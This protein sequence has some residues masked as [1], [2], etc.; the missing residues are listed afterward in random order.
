LE[1]KK[2]GHQQAESKAEQD[3]EQTPSIEELL[4]DLPLSL[5]QSLQSYRHK[6]VYPGTHKMEAEAETR[7]FEDVSQLTPL[8]S[9]SIASSLMETAASTTTSQ[10]DGFPSQIPPPPI[11]S[12]Q[13]EVE[14]LSTSYLP[15]ETEEDTQSA[16]QLHNSLLS[17][18]YPSSSSPS[19]SSHPSRSHSSHPSHSLSSLSNKHRTNQLYNELQDDI[20]LPPVYSEVP[21]LDSIPAAPQLPRIQRHSLSNAAATSSTQD[22][23]LNLYSQSMPSSNLYSQPYPPL[24]QQLLQ[25][26]ER[27]LLQKHHRP[28]PPLSSQQHHAAQQHHS[29]LLQQTQHTQ[30]HQ[31]RTEP[32]QQHQ[33]VS[34]QLGGSY[35]Q[36]R[37]SRRQ[38]GSHKSL[39]PSLPVNF[40]PPTYPSFFQRAASTSSVSVING[41]PLGMQPNQ[42][43]PQF[44]EAETYYSPSS[45]DPAVNRRDMAYSNR[46]R[47]NTH[48]EPVLPDLPLPPVVAPV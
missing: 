1:K 7:T 47:L 35:L 15:I 16:N 17:E 4:A 14:S 39:Q 37:Y 24:Q 2:I 12:R 43:V 25:E 3:V 32:Q 13:A 22:R 26:Q 46:V 11:G 41:V 45:I 38:S 5:R 30:Q 8:S 19:H 9:S 44:L 40:S 18:T 36:R 20:I 21:S 10:P 31:S 48:P 33:G 34:R 28:R 29:Q 27:H 6:E 42:A 23:N